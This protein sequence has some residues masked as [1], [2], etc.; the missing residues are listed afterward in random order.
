[1]GVVSGSTITSLALKAGTNSGY[2]VGAVV[3]ASPVAA[4]ADALVTGLT[5]QHSQ[6]DGSHTAVTATSLSVSGNTT[7]TGTTTLVGALTINSWD[8]W[9]T[10]TDTWTYVSA[11]SFKI[12]GADRTA[13]FP[14]G[15]RIKLTQTTAKYFVVTSSSFST[16]TT[17]NITAGTDYTLANA[18][19]TSPNYSYVGSPQ[20]FPG[21]FAYTSTQGGFSANQTQVSRFSVVGNNCTVIIARSANGTSNA[22]TFTQTAPITSANIANMAWVG[23]GPGADNGVSGATPVLSRITNNTTTINLYRDWTVGGAAWTAANAK[24]ADTQLTYEF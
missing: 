15:T 4:W 11:T 20:G 2:S 21:T 1:V 22:T 3:E 18:A 12:T 24:G 6:L 13:Q 7:H 16:D 17:V 8:G 9:I 10:S 5:N 23:M 19:I 14:K